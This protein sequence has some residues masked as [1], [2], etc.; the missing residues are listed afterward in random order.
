MKLSFSTLGCP[1]WAL[2]EIVA[3]G[4]EYGYDGIE[5][6]GTPPDLDVTRS[7]E[8]ASPAA[9][10]QSVTLAAD[11][12]LQFC[13]IDTSTA[14]TR[15]EP[16]ERLEHLAMARAA[17]DLAYEIGAGWVRVFGGEPRKGTSRAG[18]I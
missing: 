4:K 5:L 15:S 14:L 16:V 2:D 6:P 10:Q 9:C 11:H 13:A 7:P 18:A 17:I 12:G 3:R 1:D 8:F